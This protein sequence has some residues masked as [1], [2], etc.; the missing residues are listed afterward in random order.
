MKHIKLFGMDFDVDGKWL[1]GSSKDI[2][3]L[4]FYIF[5]FVFSLIFGICLIPYIM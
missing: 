1:I 4:S 5:L 3:K 2:D